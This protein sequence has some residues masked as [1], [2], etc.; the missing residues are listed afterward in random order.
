MAQGSDSVI[1]TMMIVTT[2]SL[3]YFYHVITMTMRCSYPGCSHAA[4]RLS[5]CWMLTFR[6]VPSAE[7]AAVYEIQL[8][9]FNGNGDGPANRRLVSL[10]DGGDAAAAAAAAAAGK[11]KQSKSLSMN[12]DL[13]LSLVS[14]SS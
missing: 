12:L 9:A 11:K 2:V 14:A 13:C 7:P 3:L 6:C 4:E 10:A 1:A 8:V 5:L